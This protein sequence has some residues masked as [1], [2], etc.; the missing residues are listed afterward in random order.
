MI[1]SAKILFPNKV[2][3]TGIGGQDL[4]LSFG[5]MQFNLLQRLAG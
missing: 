1:T 5:R 3:F 2:T 4:D